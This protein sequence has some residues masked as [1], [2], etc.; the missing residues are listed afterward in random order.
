MFNKK[1]IE[2]I[3]NLEKQFRKQECRT[4]LYIN[5]DN[6]HGY[7]ELPISDAIYAILKHLGFSPKVNHATKEIILVKNVKKS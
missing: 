5:C 7:V 4:T 3:D 1:L 2:R 6:T